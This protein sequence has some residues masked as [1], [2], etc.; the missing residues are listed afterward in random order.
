MTRA[1]V[2]AGP[3]LEARCY[4]NLKEI[5]V[6]VLSLTTP[7]V[8]TVCIMF[9]SLCTAASSREVTQNSGQL[10]IDAPQTKSILTISSVLDLRTAA[11][12]DV[13]RLSGRNG[14][15]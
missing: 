1:E 5:S 2:V 14:L 6:E 11:C 8:S 10:L 15:T 12:S 7:W 4:D 13:A 3:L 9:S